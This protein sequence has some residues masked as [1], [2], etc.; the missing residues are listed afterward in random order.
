MADHQQHSDDRRETSPYLIG[1]AAAA[2]AAGAA[3]LFFRNS[4]RDDRPADDAPNWTARDRAGERDVIGKTMLVN[5][6]RADLFKAWSE[7]ERFPDFM[8]NV[9]SVERLGDDRS[10]WTI[11]GP[12][13]R[14]VVIVSR[15][16]RTVPDREISWQSEPDSELAISGKVSF[17]EAPGKRGTH[18]TLVMAYSPPG[19]TIGKAVATL[20]QRDPATQARRNLRRFKQLME[21]GEVTVNSSPSGRRGE[22]PSTPH[23]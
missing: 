7:V 5:R 17:H 4:G 13:N 15:I 21:T 10:R 11:L 1:A 23:I 18:V 12:A 22:D 14:E 3:A 19:G 16:T 8:E 2:L 6:P 9:Q 20:F